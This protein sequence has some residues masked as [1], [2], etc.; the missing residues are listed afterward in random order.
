MRANPW[1]FF[2]FSI[3]I[4][5]GTLTMVG[6]LPGYAWVA[7][8]FFALCGIV[9]L[10]WRKGTTLNVSGPDLLPD[11]EGRNHWRFRVHNDGPEPANNVHM[12]LRDI[13]PRPKY[14]RWQADYPYPVSRVGKALNDPPSRI[15]IGDEEYYEVLT[16]AS[17]DGTLYASFDTKDSRMQTIIEPSE[18]LILKYELTSD[19]AD[20]VTFSMQMRSKD[21]VL[22]MEWN[23]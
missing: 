9:S 13:N 21:M 10:L 12:W 20:R 18:V 15:N 22:V 7:A 1:G 17:S 6:H 23:G 2:F 5:V 4:T 11:R 8:A 16:W 3:A 19:N 14:G